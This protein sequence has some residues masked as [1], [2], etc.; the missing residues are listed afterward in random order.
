M[1]HDSRPR[2]LVA[3]Y[4]TPAILAIQELFT[5]GYPPSHIGLLTHDEPKNAFAIQ[6]AHDH[7]IH[8]STASVK[9]KDC[10]NFIEDGRYDILSSVYYRDIF[11]ESVLAMF[12]GKAFNLHPGRLPDYRGCFSAPWAILNGER[13]ATF[14]YH[15]MVPEVDAGN[16]LFDG[17]VIISMVDTAFSIYHKLITRAFVS[18]T[19]ALSLVQNGEIGTPQSS[20]GTYYPR[21][22]PYDGIIQPDWPIEKVDRFIRAMYFPPYPMAV[23]VDTAGQLREIRSMDDYWE[24][25]HA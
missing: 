13:H 23:I 16:I 24:A 17:T 25:L 22:V 14:T 2:V 5:A 18:F 9:S 8:V 11:P 1:I 6:F 10:M 3:G 7:G 12:R 15:Y 21:K 20:N 4:Y 19:F